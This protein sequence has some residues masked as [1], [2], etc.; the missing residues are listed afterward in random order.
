MVMMILVMMIVKMMT[1]MILLSIDDCD[2]G[3]GNYNDDVPR[4][5]R[6]KVDTVAKKWTQ[7]DKGGHNWKKVNII[8]IRMLQCSKTQLSYEGAYPRPKRPC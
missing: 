6:T 8:K 4:N 1:M 7:W 5:N 3:G 2:D